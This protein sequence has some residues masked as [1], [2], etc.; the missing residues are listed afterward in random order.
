MYF[1]LSQKQYLILA[2]FGGL[3]LLQVLVIGYWSF[4]L[5]LSRRRRDQSAEQYREFPDGLREGN[6]PMPL[7]VVLL[8]AVV[9]VWGVGYVIAVALGGLHVQ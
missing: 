7:F 3:I 5:T 4:R 1:T 6:R 8:I 9:L 2:V